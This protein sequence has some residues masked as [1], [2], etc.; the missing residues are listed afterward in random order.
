MKPGM[1]DYVWDPTP[2]DNFGV[3]SAVWVVS[4]HGT[5]TLKS[6]E[7]MCGVRL[8]DALTLQRV[9]LS[10]KAELVD[11]SEDTVPDVPALVQEL[12]LNVFVSTFSHT[13]NINCSVSSP[14]VCRFK[15][16][17]LY[18]P[19][20]IYCES[21]VCWCILIQSRCKP[22]PNPLIEGQWGLKGPIMAQKG[23]I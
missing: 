4:A 21:H 15:V 7:V 1:V 12:M 8:Q 11:D 17:L 23:P 10:K 2:H 16:P 20:G 6:S 5:L 22:L 9:C 14:H 3:V 13:V 18:T 19:P